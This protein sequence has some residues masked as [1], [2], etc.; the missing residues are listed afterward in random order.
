MEKS[1]KYHYEELIEYLI[2]TNQ[3]E[4]IINEFQ[5]SNCVNHHHENMQNSSNFKD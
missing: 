3:V 4:I 5:D 2:A 1:K